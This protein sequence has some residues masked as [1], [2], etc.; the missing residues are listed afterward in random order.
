[1]GR[2]YEILTSRSLPL[3]V[4]T[5]LRASGHIGIIKTI[6]IYLEDI[7]ISLGTTSTDIGIALGLLSAL[8]NFPAPLVVALYRHH[9]IRRLLLISG[10]CLAPMGVAL[11]SMSTSNTQMSIYLSITGIGYCLVKMCCTVT[12]HHAA[13]NFNL[14]YSLGLSGYGAG[15]VLLP[16][17]AEFLRQAYGW[18]GG[19]LII[20]ALMANIIPV[21]MAIKLESDESSTQRNDFQSVPS[22]PPGFNEGEES[23]S[24]PSHDTEDDNRDE[25]GVFRSI[26]NSIRQSDF[27]VDPVINVLLLAIFASSMV[28]N[29]WHSFLVPH[30]LQRGISVRNTIIITFSAAIGNTC[31]R[32]VVGMLTNSLVKPITLYFFATTLNIAALLCDVYFTNFY[33]MYMTSCISAMAVGGN[34]VLGRLV[35]RDRASPEKFN[36][37]YAVDSLCFGSGS[38]LGSYLSGMIADHFSSYNATFKLLACIEVIVLLLM[39]VVRCR[40]KACSV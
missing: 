18:R 3:V 33:A 37:A 26:A 2:F 24:G 6:G 21:G 36:V 7:N 4:C 27:Y 39:V 23:N 9:S 22:S 10:T 40:P 11:T 28:W 15:M 13:Q 5:F 25:I 35:V 31:S 19:L 12:L 38:F 32:V 14:L 1:M 30:A 16:L 34:A 29:G 20:S 8:A 17:V